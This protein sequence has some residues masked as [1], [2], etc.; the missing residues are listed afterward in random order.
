[1]TNLMYDRV[2]FEP[3]AMFSP[4]VEHDEPICEGCGHLADDHAVGADVMWLPRHP[5]TAATPAFPEC[6]AS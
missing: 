3:C 2:A 6:K 1:M 5:V 4:A